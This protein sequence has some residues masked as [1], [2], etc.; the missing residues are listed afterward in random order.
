M[1]LVSS[2]RRTR[3]GFIVFLLFA[4]PLVMSPYSPQYPKLIFGYIF[5]SLLLLLWAAE[6]LLDREAILNV[7][8]TFWLGVL[9]VEVAV[10]SLVN[11]NNLR[12][13]LESLGLLICFLF[14]YLL[15]VNSTKGERDA[16]LLLGSIFAAAV[17]ASIYG[18]IQY[19]GFDILTLQRIRP[20]LG[21]LLST[22]GNKNY[23][24]GFLAYLYMPYGLLL[25][26]APRAW[27]KLSILGGMVIIWYTVM[28]IASR[29]VWLGLAIGAIFLLA[30]AL[31][32]KL[33]RLKL[34]KQN[35]GWILGL[36]ALM[37]VITAIFLFPNP[38]NLSGTVGGRIAEGVEALAE[39]YIR[40]YDWWVTWEMIKAHPFIGIGLGDFK[41]EFLEYKAK[42]LETPRGERYKDLYIPQAL[43]AHNDYLQMW[44]E[45]GTLGLLI[46]GAL[47]FMI[48][49]NGWKRSKGFAS[50]PTKGKGTEEGG[51]RALA[52]LLLLSGVLSFMGD[53]FFSFPLHLPASALC[54]VVLLALL[55]SSYLGASLQRVRPQRHS[56]RALAALASLLALTMITFAV[57]DFIADLYSTK[58]QALYEEGNLAQ[59]KEALLKSLRWDFAPK[60]ALFHLGVIYTKEGEYRKAKEVLERALSSSPRLT[61]FFNLGVVALGMKDLEEAMRYLDLVTRID[62]T[63][64]DYLYQKAQ[65][66]LLAGRTEEGLD[67]LR[68]IIAKDSSYYQAHIRLGEHFEANG[69]RDKA[70]EHYEGALSAIK[71][72]LEGLL[73][74]LK[75]P[76]LGK[77]E[78]ERI[79]GEA[80]RL[81]KAKEAVEAA[82]QTLRAGSQ[83]L[84][85]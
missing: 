79:K 17:L 57:R 6:L 71:R 63:D 11:S 25:L 40:Y 42:F 2:I 28:A 81:K 47:I 70:L 64:L 52:I 5:I 55:D 36:I 27:Q 45:L 67:I 77:A 21:S 46:I 37:A 15:L 10:I 3:L 56:K 78:Y 26:R 61:Q 51:E 23:L 76:L 44:A 59:A 66:Y 22:M 53:A 38:A 84:S 12:V 29:A 39:P 83:T 74:Q 75:Q 20:G 35:W 50:S 1:D 68:G 18:L 80:E 82:I 4:L 8:I 58:G 62:P 54:L 73:D 85:P 32:F 41:L 65:V 48:F 43:Q 13:G 69:E 7:P 24:G 30:G 14:L 31:R 16:L 60:E 49:F 19:Y 33:L 9:L 72:R 34:I